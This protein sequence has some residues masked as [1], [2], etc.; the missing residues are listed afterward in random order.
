MTI[1]E[2]NLLTEKAKTRKDGI[3]TY[4]SYYYAVKNNNFIAFADFSGNCYQRCG[5]FNVSIGKVESYDR[6]KKLL[7]WLKTQ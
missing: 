6:K 1:D 7:I 2:L 4:K 3:Y 5:F